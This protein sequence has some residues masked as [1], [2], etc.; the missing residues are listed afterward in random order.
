[1][2]T[3]IYEILNTANN[4]WYRGQVQADYGFEERWYHHKIKLNTGTHRNPH[5]Q[6]S[7]DKYG[8]GAFKFTILSR[9][10]P[11]F[12]NEL[13]EY[14]IG[15]DY[16][17]PAVSYNKKAGGGN[18]LLSEEA[19]A[20]ISEALKGT[21]N[22]MFGKNHSEDTKQKMSEAKKG[23]NHFNYGKQLT[24]EHKQKLS[25]ALKGGNN[26]MFGK[27]HTTETKKKM[28][29]AQKGEKSHMYGKNLGKETKDKISE[30]LKGKRHS[31]ESKAKMSEARK[32]ANNHN[33]KAFTVFFPDGRIDHFEC[34]TEAALAYGINR[35][36]ASRYLNGESIPGNHPSS[37]HLKDTIW[38]FI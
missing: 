21:N 33:A 7:W 26:P 17:N 29:E 15:E 25:E 20:K 18:G 30:S 34:G 32:G 31:E 3:G 14:W 16:N 35:K 37:A 36:S 19:K 28:S 2:E 23:K 6:S 4:K 9:C 38:R 27:Q 11:E 13:E 8:E 1:M 12:C 10:A 5:L 22:P 24:E